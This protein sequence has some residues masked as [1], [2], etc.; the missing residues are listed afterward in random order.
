MVELYTMRGSLFYPR[1]S[2]IPIEY[3]N[4]CPIVPGPP[5]PS[6]ASEC[7]HPP[8]SK[9]KGTHSPAGEVVGGPNSDDWRKSLVLCLLCGFTELKFLSCLLAELNEKFALQLD[10]SP[11]TDRSAYSAADSKPNRIL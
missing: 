11:C 4:V 10:T 3:H 5:T 8:E 2:Y 6:P 1:W 9:D 7:V